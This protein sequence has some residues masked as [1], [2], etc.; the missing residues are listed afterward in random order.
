MTV[1]AEGLAPREPGDTVE[2]FSEHYEDEI[3][4]IQ[5]EEEMKEVIKIL[6]DMIDKKSTE[7]NDAH[8]AHNKEVER[9]QSAHEETKGQLSMCKQSIADLE[10]FIANQ[11]TQ[12]DILKQIIDERDKEITRLHSASSSAATEPSS[13]ELPSS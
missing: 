12:I 1:D 2:Q 6:R 9:L 10:E 13:S 11:Q 7:L 3:D 5:K 4:S 8:V